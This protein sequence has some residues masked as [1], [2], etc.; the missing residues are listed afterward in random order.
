NRLGRVRGRYGE[1]KISGLRWKKLLPAVLS[2]AV[3]A[4]GAGVF[5]NT[6]GAAQYVRS[7]TT[8]LTMADYYVS[9]ETST[10]TSVV[11][12]TDGLEAAPKNLVFIFLESI[13]DEMA[14]D[15]LF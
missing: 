4:L 15:E 14:N 12:R 13:E 7:Q 1:A 5:A 2:L 6:I 11:A 8:T 9:P 10:S 3:F